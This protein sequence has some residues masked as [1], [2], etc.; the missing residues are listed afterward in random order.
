MRDGITT[1]EA[2]NYSIFEGF[3]RNEM[4]GGQ[5]LEPHWRDTQE[6]QEVLCHRLTV[7]VS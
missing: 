7:L 4:I 1:Y 5:E 6:L 2:Q 3:N